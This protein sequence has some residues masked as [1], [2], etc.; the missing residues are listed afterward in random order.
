MVLKKQILKQKFY[1]YLKEIIRWRSHKKQIK[2]KNDRNG[3]NKNRT[4]FT[5]ANKNFS[6]TFQPQEISL[7]VIALFI[8]VFIITSRQLMIF[9]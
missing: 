4:K 1:L 6:K 7:D 5:V 9:F 2:N 3:R 8:K